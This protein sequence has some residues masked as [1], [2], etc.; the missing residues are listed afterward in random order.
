MHINILTGCFVIKKK[1]KTQDDVIKRS[2]TER[3]KEGRRERR[4]NLHQMNTSVAVIVISPAWRLL[5]AAA[6]LHKRPKR[7][8]SMQT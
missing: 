8:L 6:A 3:K 7:D 5:A 2:G 1:K 4:G